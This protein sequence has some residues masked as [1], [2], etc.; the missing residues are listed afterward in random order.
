MIKI[1]DNFVQAELHP[2]QE[3]RSWRSK[4][5]F[6][7][8]TS[9]GIDNIEVDDSR[10]TLALMMCRAQVDGKRPWGSLLPFGAWPMSCFLTNSCRWV[11][12][13][14]DKQRQR[15][16]PPRVSGQLIPGGRRESWAA[17]FR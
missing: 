16:N 6:M 11:A 3:A 7:A 8:I 5:D 9:P 13:H 15:N 10:K 1:T 17:R 4:R 12:R 2:F 14:C